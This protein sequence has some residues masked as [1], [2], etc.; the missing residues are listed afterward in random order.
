MPERQLAKQR[1]KQVQRTTNKQTSSLVSVDALS[2]PRGPGRAA[3]AGPGVGVDDARTRGSTGGSAGRL[4]SGDLVICGYSS[5]EPDE[6][7]RGLGCLGSHESLS[8]YPTTD[9]R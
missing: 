2:T 5:V 7:L 6:A 9:V 4:T 8:E 3:D 1:S